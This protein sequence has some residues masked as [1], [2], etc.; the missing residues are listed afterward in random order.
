MFKNAFL[1][2]PDVKIDP[3][4]DI[5]LICNTSGSTGVPKGVL[6]THYTCLGI[7]ACLEYASLVNNKH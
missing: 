3:K 4:Y 2:F 6:H 7:M 5:A 1:A